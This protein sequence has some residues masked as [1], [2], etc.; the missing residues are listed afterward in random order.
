MIQKERGDFS[1]WQVWKEKKV[2]FIV[3][4]CV[5]HLCMRACSA[6]SCV[7]FFADPWPVAT[8]LLCPWD[9]SGKSTGVGCHFL[10]QGIFPTQGLNLSPA[11]AGGFF[12]TEPCGKPGVYNIHTYIYIYIH[13]HTSWLNLLVFLYLYRH[14][15]YKN[16]IFVLLLDYVRTSISGS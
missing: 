4:L 10:L 13:T 9:F 12:T 8:S 11:L 14:L 7:L 15:Y 6:L 1:N 5:G 16:H 3:C 2:F